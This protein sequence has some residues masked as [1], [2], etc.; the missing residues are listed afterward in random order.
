LSDLNLRSRELRKKLLELSQNSGALH[1]APAFSCLEIVDSVYRELMPRFVNP[2]FIM[3]KGHGYLAQLVV[4]ETLRQLP[5]GVF[6]KIGADGSLFGGHPDRGQPGIIASTGS[7]GH[8]L[9][10]A[11]GLSISKVLSAKALNKINDG[12][13]VALISDGELQEGSTWENILNAPSLKAENLLLIID[14]ND[15]QTVGKTSVTHPALYP[16]Q[17]KLVSFGWSTYSVDGHSY[18]DLKLQFAKVPKNFGC[19]AII[20]STI[21]GKGIRFMESQSIWHYR[22]PNHQEFALALKE[23]GF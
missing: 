10:L 3:S 22:S 8:G 23:L 7:L 1:L 14:N 13:T 5:E 21:K 15:M 20:A 4:L 17:E 12:L 19:L 11:V 9:G 2:Q 16:L 6:E 18:D